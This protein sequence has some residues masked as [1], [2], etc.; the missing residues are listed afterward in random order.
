MPTK[1]LQDFVCKLEKLLRDG[2]IRRKTEGKDMTES[3]KDFDDIANSESIEE[4]KDIEEQPE[5]PRKNL[6]LFIEDEIL[7][8]IVDL[9]LIESE[10]RSGRSWVISSSEGN[11]KLF[12]SN[13]F[14]NEVLNFSV[15]RRK[16]GAKPVRW[17]SY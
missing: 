4:P 8:V 2:T 17:H 10:S 1:Q 3:N 11:L 13:G 9:R 5:E 6:T 16:P 14:R 12:D 7:T 15:T